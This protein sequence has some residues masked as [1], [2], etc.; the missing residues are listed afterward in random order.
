MTNGPVPSVPFSTVKIRVAALVFCGDE[1]A[2]IRRDRPHST[3]YTPPG[4]NVEPG[5]DLFAAL[6]RE[7]S[8]ELDLDIGQ[9]EGGELLWVVDQRVTRPGPTPSPRK[10]HLIHRLHITP[11]VRARLAVE[12]YDELPDGSHE[13]GVIEWVDYRRTAGLALF[14]PIGRAL[15]ALADPRRPVADAALGAVTD[16]T[17]TWV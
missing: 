15:A 4:G 13:I 5:E 6:A 7:L 14:P 16:D 12:E 8:E 1:V 11:D 9:A 10:L 3:H 2:L 17:Y